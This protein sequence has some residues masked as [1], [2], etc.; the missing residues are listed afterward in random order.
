MP[1]GRPSEVRQGAAFPP[2]LWAA[3]AIAP[4][5][6]G[7][8]NGQKRA[9]IAIVGAGYS[10]LSAAIHLAE[11]GCNVAV[12]DATGPGWGASG[13]N[14]GQVI[15]GLKFDPDEIERRFGHDIG[16]RMVMWAGNAPS[17]VFDLIEK[18]DIECAPV[19]NGWV[20]PAYTRQSVAVIESRY[21][22][23]AAR[24]ADVRMILAKDLPAMLGTPAFFGGWFDGRGG[25]IQ[26]LSYAR[27]LAH[28]AKSLGVEI[29]TETAVRRLERRNSGWLLQTDHGGIAAARIIVATNA[30]SGALV[31]GLEQSVVPVRTAQ[32]ATRPL[33]E[34]LLK[35]ILPGRQ[36]ASDTRRL[37]TSFRISPDNRLVMGGSGATGGE[38]HISLER[39][40][41]AAGAELFGH[42]A[43]LEWEYGWSGHLAVTSD[44]V[45]HIH[46][47]D[48]SILVSLGCNGR[49]I[50]ISTAMGK[51]LAE[52]FLGKR[53]EDMELG[54]SR[55]RPYA[56]HGLRNIGIAVATQWKRMQD[57]HERV[58]S[59]KSRDA[60]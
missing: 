32:V 33:S 44:H 23:W 28:A 17:L 5:A 46:E 31:P 16:R 58:R 55:I 24:G 8:L 56:F 7:V 15:P 21:A 27:G 30:Y 1:E 49:G 22:Q 57:R 50:A 54:I 41:H 43:D 48:P 18:F 60:S 29:Y 10:G 45:P 53:A 39:Y 12:V 11:G 26:P 47:P 3:T 2:S 14:N 40:L 59:L 51:L 9:D 25:S 4:P 38:H 20:Q 19:R 36:V 52:R 42:L 35:T 13:R 37:L 6:T 34:N